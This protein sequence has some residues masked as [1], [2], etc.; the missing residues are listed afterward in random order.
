MQILSPFPRSTTVS[1]T[2]K[3][4]SSD[5]RATNPAGNLCACSNLSTP[6]YIMRVPYW[7]WRAKIY[8]L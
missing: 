2:L 8:M 6:S 4:G 1:E 5:L 7:E 3:V